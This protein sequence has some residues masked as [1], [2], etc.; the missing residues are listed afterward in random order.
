MNNQQ[1][2]LW[3]KMRSMIRQN[4]RKFQYRNDRNIYEGLNDLGLTVEDAWREILQL[5]KHFY[6]IDNMPFYNQSKN[7]LT[8][9]KPIKQKIA[10][11]KLILDEND[12]VVAC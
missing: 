4:K 8:F 10:Y 3:N 6:V 2:I 12:D 1:M 5:N 9:K 7:S 11:I